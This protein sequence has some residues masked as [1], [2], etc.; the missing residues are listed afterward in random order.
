MA[1]RVSR[2]AAGCR[3][4]MKA[5]RQG[6]RAGEHRNHMHST[7]QQ[8]AQQGRHAPKL[9]GAGTSRALAVACQ[10]PSAAQP[11]LAASKKTAAPLLTTPV[12][13]QHGVQHAHEGAGMRGHVG[14]ASLLPQIPSRHRRH[15]QR[16]RVPL[17]LQYAERHGRHGR[18]AAAHR[19][20]LAKQRV[21]R[22]CIAKHRTVVAACCTPCVPTHVQAGVHRVDVVAS[23]QQLLDGFLVLPWRAVH[24]GRLP[25]AGRHCKKKERMRP[26]AWLKGAGQ[27]RAPNGPPHGCRGR[28]CRRS[29][30]GVRVG[31]AAARATQRG[32]KPCSG[33]CRPAG[34]RHTRGRS[35]PLSRALE[36][37]PSA[38]RRPW[39]TAAWGV[40]AWRGC[41]RRR[42]RRLQRGVGGGSTAAG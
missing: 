7:A 35:C 15:H 5:A 30:A 38:W 18:H 10:H 28:H 3:A 24:N 39:G 29:V 40:A 41:R 31:C 6:R 12:A 11:S 8:N 32:P 4:V 1:A 16:I 20:S 34:T 37:H 22:A 13:R 25:R 26:W 17:G 2:Q 36:T 19:G 23:K 14:L 42:C 33:A 9:A 21:C 27:G